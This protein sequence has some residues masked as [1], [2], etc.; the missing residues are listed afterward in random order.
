MVGLLFTNRLLQH[1]WAKAENLAYQNHLLQAGEA[2]E[3]LLTDQLRKGKLWFK[4]TPVLQFYHFYEKAREVNSD[5]KST[6]QVA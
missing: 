5:K 4:T 3:P 2:C 1:N 6:S